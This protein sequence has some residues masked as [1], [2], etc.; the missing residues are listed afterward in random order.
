MTRRF[1]L[2]PVFMALLMVSSA[3][4]AVALKPEQRMV[5]EAHCYAEKQ[6]EHDER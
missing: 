5:D 6:Q 2:V 1:P 4:L 3:A